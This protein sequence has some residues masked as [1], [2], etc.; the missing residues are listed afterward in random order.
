MPGNL[1]PR[2]PHT[3]LTRAMP[4]LTPLWAANITP[5]TASSA[6]RSLWGW[7]H[8]HFLIYLLLLFLIPPKSLHFFFYSLL[9]SVHLHFLLLAIFSFHSSVPLDQLLGPGSKLVNSDCLS[10]FIRLNLRLMAEYRSL[11]FSGIVLSYPLSHAETI[12]LVIS[13]C[14][15]WVL[16]QSKDFL[17]FSKG[18]LTYCRT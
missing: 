18:I 15:Q 6:E 3:N 10:A 13:A 5:P 17:F 1:P 8:A 4:A 7:K 11:H 2:Q 14:I 9:L 12:A 16:S